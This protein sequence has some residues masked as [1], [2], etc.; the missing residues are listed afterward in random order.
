MNDDEMNERCNGEISPPELTFFWASITL[1]PLT[2]IE[3]TTD[4]SFLMFL[5]DTC[6]EE[7]V[8][9]NTLLIK[10]SYKVAYPNLFTSGD[11]SS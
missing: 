1:T 6:G 5:L 8:N 10:R 4:G 3:R 11:S 2:E 9:M 7:N